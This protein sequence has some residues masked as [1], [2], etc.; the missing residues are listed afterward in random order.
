MVQ[1]QEQGLPSQDV[2]VR[3]RDSSPRMVEEVRVLEA[4]M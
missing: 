2:P 1:E 3:L 4:P